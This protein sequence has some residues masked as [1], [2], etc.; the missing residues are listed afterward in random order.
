MATAMSTALDAA[1]PTTSVSSAEATAGEP[2]GLPRREDSSSLAAGYVCV[3]VDVHCA[4]M[5][6]V[7]DG[8]TER[9]RGLLAQ[10]LFVD[11]E[12]GA[13]LVWL[14]AD[15]DEV[16]ALVHNVGERHPA[17][18]FTVQTTGAAVAVR[19]AATDEELVEL[20]R[21]YMGEAP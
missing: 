14:D 20:E 1:I 3:G 4:S 5:T 11:R 7:P 8:A 2:A 15:S 12:P 16:S 10:R 18:R 6:R 17:A 9:F 13:L 21:R 19:M